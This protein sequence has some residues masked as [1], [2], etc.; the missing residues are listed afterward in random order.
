MEEGIRNKELD[1][2]MAYAKGCEILDYQQKICGFGVE[3]KYKTK[4]SGSNDAGSG[5]D[6]KEGRNC[7][8]VPW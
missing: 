7:H 5:R 3:L 2:N 4:K 1:K 6:G 8:S